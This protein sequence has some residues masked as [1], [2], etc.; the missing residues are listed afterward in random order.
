MNFKTLAGTVLAGAAYLSLS[1]G[2]AYAIGVTDVDYLS[3]PDD[4]ILDMGS[5]TTTL[6]NGLDG[7]YAGGDW[8]FLDST[9]A[10]SQTFAGATFVVEAEFT[11]LGENSFDRTSGDLYVSWEEGTPPI[12][13]DFLIA[14]EA[15][16]HVGAYL[17]NDVVI[18]G[19]PG[20]EIGT[21]QVSW[22]ELGNSL[23]TTFADVTNIAIFGRLNSSD[24]PEPGILAL[25][26]LGLAG[27]GFQRKRSA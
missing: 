12:D 15:G 21:F 23:T 2:N 17:F 3:G 16:G 13:M 18:N 6:V 20:I 24:V 1:A 14:V 8:S 10:A 5:A 22:D 9:N 27:L 4:A 11:R 26:G 25:F 7:N 19:T